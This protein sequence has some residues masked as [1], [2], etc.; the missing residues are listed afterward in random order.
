M[1]KVGITTTHHFPHHC[2]HVGHLV[3]RRNRR[4]KKRKEKKR[5]E[6][7]R[8]EKKGRIKEEEK[9]NQDPQTAKM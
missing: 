7:K 5:K 1:E 2:T 6:K 8:K 9:I 3:E 4:K